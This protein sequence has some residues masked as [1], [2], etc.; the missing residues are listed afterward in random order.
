MQDI[1]DIGSRESFLLQL[2]YHTDALLLSVQKGW[3]HSEQ[4]FSRNTR[5]TQKTQCKDISCL[6]LDGSQALRRALFT[7]TKL[8]P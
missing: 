5:V 8:L 4:Q 6:A 1:I 2:L 3:A 7:A